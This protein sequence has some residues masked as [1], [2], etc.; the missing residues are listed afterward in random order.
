MGFVNWLIHLLKDPRS[1]IASWI[2]M[3]LVPTY[4]FIF[5]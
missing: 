5:L 1:A 3:G 4:G 2:A